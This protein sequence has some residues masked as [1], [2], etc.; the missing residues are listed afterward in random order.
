MIR[1]TLLGVGLLAASTVHAGQNFNYSYFGAS[2]IFS[3]E[4]IAN[5]K[6]D[7]KG[8][9]IGGSYE[10]SS[11][12]VNLKAGFSHNS[13]DKDETGGSDISSSSYSVG[14]EYVL[15]IANGF[16]LLP[17]AQASY[18]HAEQTVGALKNTQGY[19]AFA[20]GIQAKYRVK[21]GLIL[22]GEVAHVMY[23]EDALDNG[24][25]FA[26]G[27]EYEVDSTWGIGVTKSWMNDSGATAVY[28]K[29]FY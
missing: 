15:S 24:T 14:V 5:K 28:V 4:D 29:I 13:I 22:D 18:I 10:L 17:G 3:Y 26:I 2:A 1:K 19:N 8:F 20:P 12:P 21:N 11:I 16:D 25:R 27:A 6:L 7:G 9:L 23:S